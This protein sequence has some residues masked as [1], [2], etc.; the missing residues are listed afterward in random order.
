MK[1]SIITLVAAVALTSHATAGSIKLQAKTSS[2]GR[3]TDK[4]WTTSWGSYDKDIYRGRAV[5]VALMSSTSGTCT[6]ECY[7]I[8]AKAG[9]RTNT[10][11]KDQSKSVTLTANARKMVEFGKL[12][13]ENDTRYAA[14]DIRDQ[15]GY[16]YKGW[17]IRVT[18]SKG[19]TLASKGARPPMVKYVAS[20]LKDQ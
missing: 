9:E 1:T 16:K 10:V 3:S 6:V 20:W 17:V 19:N 2:M 13:V 8:V 5:D 11:I 15:E 18:D 12:F 14:L 7:W 4:K